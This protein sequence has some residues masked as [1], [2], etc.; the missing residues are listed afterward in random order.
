MVYI[1][2]Y[3]AVRLT[4]SLV[5]VSIIIGVGMFFEINSTHAMVQK[6][7]NVNVTSKAHYQTSHNLLQNSKQH[8]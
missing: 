2:I 4:L 6:I 3:V 7:L 1:Y 5:S 8:Y